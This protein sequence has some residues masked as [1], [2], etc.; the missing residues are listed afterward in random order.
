MG[1]NCYLILLVLVRHNHDKDIQFCDDR[2]QHF[3]G[4]LCE[5]CDVCYEV[6]MKMS[7]YCDSKYCDCENDGVR[8]E[9]AEVH[10]QGDD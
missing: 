3:Q 2:N 9:Q 10:T 8:G 5:R 6:S 4:D 7:E 1:R